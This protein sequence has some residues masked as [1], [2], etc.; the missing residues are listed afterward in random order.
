M[1]LNEGNKVSSILECVDGDG[2]LKGVTHIIIA[3]AYLLNLGIKNNTWTKEEAI[4]IL[5]GIG[6]NA[7]LAL[8]AVSAEVMH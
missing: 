1:N 6:N 8:N 3:L 7:E 4:K 2:F 5:E